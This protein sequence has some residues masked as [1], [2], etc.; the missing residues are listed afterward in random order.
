MSDVI[1]K[2]TNLLAYTEAHLH[3]FRIVAFEA[4]ISHT[5]LG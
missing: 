1:R 5:N 2:R 3:V 4:A